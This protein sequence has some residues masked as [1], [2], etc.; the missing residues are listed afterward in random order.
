[1]T[2][3]YPIRFDLRELQA[4]MDRLPPKAEC[5]GLF[6]RVIVGDDMSIDVESLEEAKEL[7]AHLLRQG[8][9]PSDAERA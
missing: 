6:I 1:M 7:V 2:V 4:L 3:K 9:T 5:G 8:Q